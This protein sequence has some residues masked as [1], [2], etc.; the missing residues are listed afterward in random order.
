MGRTGLERRTFFL[1]YYF[2]LS[3]AMT[4]RTDN[5]AMAAQIFP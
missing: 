1:M 3:V 5:A 2:F 4:P